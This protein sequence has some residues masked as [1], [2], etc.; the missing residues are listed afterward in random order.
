MTADPHAAARASIARGS[1]SFALASRLLDPQTR[2]RATLLY[3]WCRHCDD[4][5]D[6]QDHGAGKVSATDSPAQR[7]AI[8]R[9][10]TTRALA[11]EQSGQ[12]PFDALAL[13]ARET[14][15]PAR[16]PHDLLDG[17]AMDVND[18][19]FNEEADLLRYCYHVAG[20]VGIMVALAMGVP[21]HDHA[22]LARASDLGIAFQLNNIARDIGEDAAIGRRYLPA[23][24]LA[25]EGLTAA[26]YLA[27]E[28]RAA[29]HRIASRLVHLA[30][31]YEASARHGVAALGWRQAW[32]ILSAARIYGG[33]G[34]KIRAMGP[35]A[36]D[37][38]THTTAGE[39][40]LAVANSLAPA[41]LR[42]RRPGTPRT[43][44]WTPA[45][46]PV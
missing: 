31:R 30:E 4:V 37:G 28:H 23:T 11:G 24:W 21:P 17:F 3:A 39:K 45:F 44:L 42:H 15:M 2:T 7:L 1:H 46:E 16:Y 6:G 25:A 41:L 5:I 34:R 13:V 19:A 22:T 38:R 35:Q 8:L 26:D 18:H 36:L 29:L 33:I 12:M 10:A 32:A 43:G 14:A 27:R 9:A 40:L 20:A